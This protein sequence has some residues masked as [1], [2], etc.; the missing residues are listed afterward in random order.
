MST[1]QVLNKET[2]MDT[3][4]LTENQI[5][6]LNQIVNAGK[7]DYKDVDGRAVRALSARGLVKVTENSKGTFVTPT[8]KGKKLN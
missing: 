8:A 1:S 7:V 5:E 6:N 2:I 4:K 3:V